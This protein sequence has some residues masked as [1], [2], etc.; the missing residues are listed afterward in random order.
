MLKK[1]IFLGFMVLLSLLCIIGCQDK[2]ESVIGAW[3]SV[4]P[5]G[6]TGAVEVFIFEKDKFHLNGR[7]TSTANYKNED[8]HVVVYVDNGSMNI[9]FIDD[10][11]IM[12]E[13]PMSKVKCIRIST[14][15]AKKI[16]EENNKPKPK[17]PIKDWKAF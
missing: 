2:T 8:K 12:I 5:S 11:T 10:N 13:F 3:K 17:T 7:K 14:D 15:D 4:S 9:V 16:N 6:L 1:R